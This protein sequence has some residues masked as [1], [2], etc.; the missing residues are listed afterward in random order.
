MSNLNLQNYDLL[1][2][3]QTKEMFGIIQDAF[4]NNDV[5][6]IVIHALITALETLFFGY[7]VVI[8]ADSTTGTTGAASAMPER[9]D[10]GTSDVVKIRTYI[11]VTKYDT[12]KL[13]CQAK[14]DNLS[15]T[16]NA[17]IEL[18][19]DTLSDDILISNT[20]YTGK[21]IS[22]DVSSLSGIKEITVELNANASPDPQIVYMKYASI[23]GLTKQS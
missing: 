8:Y 5:D 22:I 23:I 18:N 14:F 2:L 12:I 10:N 21:E 17:K 11:D 13:L 6:H 19:V 9:E 16:V 1:D 7:P 3:D 4:N 15:P 20:T